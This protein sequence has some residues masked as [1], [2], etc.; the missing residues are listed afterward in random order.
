MKKVILIAIVLGALQA[1]SVAR[2]G[3]SA[4]IGAGQLALGAAQVV[5]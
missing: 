4:A 5:L 1:C 2:V 3:T